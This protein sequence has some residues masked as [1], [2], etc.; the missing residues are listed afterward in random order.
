MEPS[1][2]LSIHSAREAAEL[3]G[4]RRCSV[5]QQ[6][7]PCDIVPVEMPSGWVLPRLSKVLGTWGSSLIC[8]Q[9]WSV[10]ELHRDQARSK[11]DLF[12]WAC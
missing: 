5:P 11:W 2:L 10:G 3:L 9:D 6:H 1:N 7:I 12:F 8:R 4:S